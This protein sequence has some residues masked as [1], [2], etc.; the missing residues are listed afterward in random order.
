MGKR[1]CRTLSRISN[2]DPAHVFSL[3]D[4]SMNNVESIKNNITE[5]DKLTHNMTSRA[6]ESNNNSFITR[7]RIYLMKLIAAYRYILKKPTELQAFLKQTIDDLEEDED[8][9]PEE[10]E[11]LQKLRDMQTTAGGKRR[12]KHKSKKAKKSKKATKSKKAKKSI[13]NRKH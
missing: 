10:E 9:T 12:R 6:L 13:K 11:I 4:L 2:E 3:E 1:F 5:L 8:K 7:E